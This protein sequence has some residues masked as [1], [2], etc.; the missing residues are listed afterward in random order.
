MSAYLDWISEKQETF[1]TKKL[2]IVYWN[3]VSNIRKMC[4]T[5]NSITWNLLYLD[6]EKRFLSEALKFSWPLS[7]EVDVRIKS[8]EYT[9]D[10]IT[11]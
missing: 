1:D 3:I 5:T 10:P 9:R 4:P 2:K 6:S 7:S 11:K 8:F